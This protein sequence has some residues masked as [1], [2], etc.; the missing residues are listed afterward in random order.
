MDGWEL[1]AASFVLIWGEKR[2]GEGE[3][4][5]DV[6]FLVWIHNIDGFRYM[7]LFIYMCVFMYLFYLFP[8]ATKPKGS[9]LLF[10]N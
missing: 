4:E 1:I 10:P 5:D 2:G 3:I 7:Y 8:Y 9:W 6:F